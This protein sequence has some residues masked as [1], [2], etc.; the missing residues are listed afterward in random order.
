MGPAGEERFVGD[1][2]EALV[3]MLQRPEPDRRR[4]LAREAAAFDWENVFDRYETIYYELA[5][6]AAGDR[7]G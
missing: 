4:R 5:M 7:A 2:A 6:P 3:A 1:L